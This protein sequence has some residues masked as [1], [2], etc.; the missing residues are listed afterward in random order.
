MG[1][2]R[3]A[4]DQS[5]PPRT[6]EDVAASGFPVSEYYA[7]NESAKHSNSRELL[8]SQRPSGKAV[9]ESLIRSL[10]CTRT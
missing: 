10:Y 9:D 7:R 4:E 5:D 1:P 8:E 6:P 2:S 3:N